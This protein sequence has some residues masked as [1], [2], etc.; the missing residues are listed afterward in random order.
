MWKII[1]IMK[2]ANVTAGL[3]H[4]HL[5]RF[6]MH[7]TCMANTECLTHLLESYSDPLFSWPPQEKKALLIL[8]NMYKDLYFYLPLKDILLWCK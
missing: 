5:P 3:H 2:M 1:I 6:L 8:P 4:E 7:S